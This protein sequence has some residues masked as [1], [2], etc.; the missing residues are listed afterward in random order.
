VA[1]LTLLA[2]LLLSA[3]SASGTKTAGGSANAAPPSTS[4]GTSTEQT[5]STT[6]AALP[7][8]GKPPVTI[9]DKNYTEQFLLGDL[10]RE[11]LQAQGFSVDLNQNIGPTSV[12]L[13]AMA[14]GS[15]DMYPEYLNVYDSAVAQY[16]HGFGSQSA[17]YSAAQRYAIAHN[18]QLLVA[19]PFSDT[20]AIGV[21]VGYAAV[22]HLRTLRDLAKVAP[23]LTVG[24]P[25]QFAQTHP[26]LT[27][28]EQTYGFTPAAFKTLAVGDQYSALNDGTIQ[29]ADVN[30][31]DGQL[32]SGDYRLLSDPNHVL[33]WGNAVPVVASR[34]LVQEG[35]AFVST[36]NR[37][38][39]LLT[40]PVMRELNQAVDVAGEDPATVAKQFLETHNMIPPSS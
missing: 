29:A 11:A 8:T 30:T 13:Q 2:A 27:D 39:A 14:S 4:T 10:Y 40:I 31:T 9:G 22:N 18:M 7:G 19:T 17:A 33:S 16:T 20:Q 35:P 28:L 25:P 36:I 34:A 23:T 3:C 32:A 38:S 24:G 1:G 26:G 12:T 21:T 6:T 5:T 37:I 15:L